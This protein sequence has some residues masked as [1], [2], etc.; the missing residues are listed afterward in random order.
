M[1]VYSTT[2]IAS[3]CG[4]SERQVQR[5]IASGKLKATHIKGNRY[6]VAEGDLQPFLPREIVDS[7]SERLEA[8]E[9]R[10]DALEHPA[11]RLF[12]AKILYTHMEKP[13]E[14]I[15]LQELAD[16]LGIAR[17]TLLERVTNER[18][19]LAHIAVPIAG[20]PTHEHTRYFTQEQAER[21]R[22]WHRAHRMHDREE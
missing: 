22:V 21:V 11:K 12:P 5:W 3:R 18:N 9:R 19:G 17:Q 6:E 1:A 10:V 13:G 14:T 4:K 2:E 20:R 8:L 15:T 7:I 16:E